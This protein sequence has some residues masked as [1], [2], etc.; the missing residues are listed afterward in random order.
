MDKDLCYALLKGDYEVIKNHFNINNV[1]ESYDSR[2][3]TALSI[4]VLSNDYKTVKY[5][6]DIGAFPNFSDNFQ[7]TILMEFVEIQKPKIEIL[8]ILIEHGANV[9]DKDRGGGTA[10]FKACTNKSISLNLV[11][12]LIESGSDLSDMYFQYDSD[13]AYRGIQH[14]IEDCGNLIKSDIKDYIKYLNTL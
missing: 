4:A 7:N 2:E 13:P 11:K 12:Y 9:Y 3:Y 8:K 6:L 1:N 10:L 5:L 14:I